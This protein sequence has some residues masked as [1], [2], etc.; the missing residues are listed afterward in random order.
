MFMLAKKAKCTSAKAIKAGKPTQKEVG[1]KT[2]IAAK[3]SNSTAN[4]KPG[5][6]AT[7][8]TEQA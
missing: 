8:T 2:I 6:V 4:A 1:S 3:T 7:K 5:N